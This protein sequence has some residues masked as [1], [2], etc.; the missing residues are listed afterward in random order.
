MILYDLLT[1]VKLKLNRL[2]YICFFKSKSK[3]FE[4]KFGLRQGDTFLLN[5]ALEK[6][7]RDM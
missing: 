3:D 1:I 5:I 6:M 7:V 4:M 2:P